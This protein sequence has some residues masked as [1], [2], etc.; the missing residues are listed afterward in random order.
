MERLDFHAMHLAIVSPY[1]PN[2]TGIGQYG[3]YVS[4]LLAQSGVFHRIT[5]L[6]GASVADAVPVSAYHPES[7]TGYHPES[8]TGYHPESL[9][10][11]RHL[12]RMFLPE[13]STGTGYH[14][15]SLTGYH[16]ESPISSRSSTGT[17]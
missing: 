11:S 17:G 7:P 5:V 15:E 16:P 1:P 12:S 6:T 8:P 10:S 2:I 9:I 14:P 13:S 4:R 3:Y